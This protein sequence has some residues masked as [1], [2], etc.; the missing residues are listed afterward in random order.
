[1]ANKRLVEATRMTRLR[2]VTLVEIYENQKRQAHRFDHLHLLDFLEALHFDISENEFITLLQ[3]LS[4]RHYITYESEKDR[5][6]GD[7]FLRSLQ[8]T[9]AGRDIVLKIKKDEAIRIE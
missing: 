9:P 5:K 4:E 8:I 2:G 3:D 1:M 7:L 6:T